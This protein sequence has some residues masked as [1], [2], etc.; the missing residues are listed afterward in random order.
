MPA[1]VIKGV[2]FAAD[3]EQGDRLARYFYSHGSTR[4]QLRKI[5]NFEEL[6]HPPSPSRSP[7]CAL[8]LF[9]SMTKNFLDAVILSPDSLHRDEESLSII[10]NAGKGCFAKFTLSRFAVLRAIRSGM[11]NG[12]SMTNS[13]FR[14]VARG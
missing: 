10:F 11:A 3:V 13:V 7:G 4:R 14:Q 12:L 8:E 2:Y 6:C 5:R 1:G 9:S